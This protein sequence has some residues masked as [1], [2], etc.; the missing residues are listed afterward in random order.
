VAKYKKNGELMK[1]MY[2]ELAVQD[3]VGDHVIGHRQIRPVPTQAQDDGV[4]VAERG[5]QTRTR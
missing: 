4:Q 2:D 3:I 5:H 1:D